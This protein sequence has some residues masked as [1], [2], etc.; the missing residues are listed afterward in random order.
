[1]TTLVGLLRAV[2][3]GGRK[4]VMAD[5]REALA[6]AGFADPRT[7]L[8]SGNVLV[9]TELAPAAAGAAME[10]A[11][12]ERFGFPVPVLVRTAEELAAIAATDPFGGEATDPARRLV[13]FFAEPPDLAPL[14]GA[15]FTPERFAP[16]GCELHLWCPGGVGRS[17][18]LA[19]RPMARV[20]GSATARNWNTVTKLTELAATH[21]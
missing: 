17:P 2:N 1:V 9:G 7:Y 4:V 18:M 21:R 6:A 16:A 12:A 19:S 20:W 8:A 14:E 13:A 10:A 3:V 5:L 15:D 11:I